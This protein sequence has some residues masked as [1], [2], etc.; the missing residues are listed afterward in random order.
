MH[1]KL[2]ECRKYCM[3]KIQL[4]TQNYGVLEYNF[5]V[6]GFVRGFVVYLLVESP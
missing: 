2:N 6:V 1:P 4:P 5:V 3:Q